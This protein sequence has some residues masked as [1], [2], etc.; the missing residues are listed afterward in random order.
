M[1]EII[2]KTIPLV[3]VLS[4]L[5]N[6]S[7]N[8]QWIQ[9]NGPYG[10]ASINCFATNDSIIYVGTFVGFFMSTNNGLNWV[11]ANN[12]KGLTENLKLINYED[13]V[14]KVAGM[15]SVK[16]KALLQN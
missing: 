15:D 5:L 7:L 3:I 12:L 9:T 11:K 14:Q 10:G 6:I 8:A 2:K 16:R 4:F 13:S 1:K